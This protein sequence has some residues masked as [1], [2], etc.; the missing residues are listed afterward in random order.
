MMD[1]KAIKEL[2][3][4]HEVSTNEHVSQ[5]HLSE[6]LGMAAG[7]VHLYLKRLAHKG[8]IKVSGI[9][10]RRLKYLLTPRGIAEKTRLTYEFALISYKF[11][12]AATDDIRKKLSE[13]ESPQR[14]GVVVFG[15]GE[16]AELC[17]QIIKEFN[18]QVLGVVDDK[19]ETTKYFGHPVIPTDLLGNLRFEKL[20]IA[21]VDARDE[22]ESMLK[23]LDIR[24]DKACWILEVPDG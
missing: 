23:K 19:I 12:M 3:I 5:R 1:S 6:K 14:P 17:L 16:P 13:I 7:L 8:F 10:K 24:S 4:L 18:I 15:T 22:V 20:I 2:E 11:I 21:K 9:N